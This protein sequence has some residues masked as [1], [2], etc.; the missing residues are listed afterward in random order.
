MHEK[1]CFAVVLLRNLD[2]LTTED[3]VLSHLKTMTELPIKS[4]RIGRD[5]LTN[6]SRGVCY[7]EM[8]TVMDAMFLHNHL[9]G[10]PPIIDE[11]LVS[12][13][14]ARVG[15]QTNL[16]QSQTTGA[17]ASVALAAAQWSHQDHTKGSTAGGFLCAGTCKMIFIH[18]MYI[19]QHFFITLWSTRPTHCHGREWSLFLHVCF[20][21]TYVVRPHF[22]KSRIC[23]SGQ[24]DHWWLACPFFHCFHLQCKNNILLIPAH[25]NPPFVFK[26][27]WW[28][29]HS[30]IT[31]TH[32]KPFS[33]GNREIGRILSI[34]VCQ[35]AGR[36][37]VLSG[38]LSKIL[39][40]WWKCKWLLRINSNC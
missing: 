23:G 2:A 24:V 32:C 13:S 25:R 18:F 34:S 17:A 31:S 29:K 1:F 33:W 8:N 15:N 14:Y 9:L 16:A 10:Q 36:E 26:R 38:I 12:V 19:N 5:S 3:S 22:S 35:D 11:K 27:E 21:L 20:V 4:I 37:T 40:E 39:Q 30:R 6:T 28:F 7:V